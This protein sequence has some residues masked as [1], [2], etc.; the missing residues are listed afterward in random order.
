[1]IQGSLSRRYAKGLFLLAVDEGRE[2]EIAGELQGVTAAY[3]NSQLRSLLDNP[4]FDR[5]DRKKIL[6]ETARALQL[7]PAAT[8]FLCL[9]LDRGRPALLPS[10]LSHYR[11]LLDEAKG[12]VQARVVTTTRL[13]GP[14]VERF[15][16]ALEKISGKHVVLTTETDPSLIGGAVVEIE[17]KTY[18]ASIRTHLD[19]MQ[20]H[21]EEGS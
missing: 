21:L 6:I 14:A 3:E 10:V 15:R 5:R 13:E 2:E 16:D 1:M 11:R 7:S 12:R 18:D 20:E 9:L 4:A 17:G 8:H 19:R